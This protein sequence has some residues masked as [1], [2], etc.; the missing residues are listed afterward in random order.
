[1]LGERGGGLVDRV[2]LVA[3]H[4]DVARAGAGGLRD[5]AVDLVRARGAVLDEVVDGVCA[6]RGRKKERW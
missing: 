6:L 4:D 3:A 2:E 5:L 1:M